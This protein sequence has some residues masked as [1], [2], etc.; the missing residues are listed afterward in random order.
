MKILDNYKGIALLSD[1]SESDLEYA[2]ELIRQG[3][4]VG[5]PTETVYGLGADALNEEAVKK[6]F[7]AKGRP[8]DNPLIVHI[9]DTEQMELYAHDILPAAY[10]LAHDFWPGPLT[11]ILPK[12]D[13]IPFAAS[14]GLDTVGIRMPQSEF[15]RKLIRKSGRP[16]AAPSANISGYPS[17]TTAMHVCH[18]M[19]GKIKAVVDGGECRVGLESTV[20]AFEKNNTIRILRPGFITPNDL[21]PYA[22]KIITDKAIL[23]GLS[24]DEKASSP[25]MKYKHYSPAANIIL[26]EAA[27]ADF[28]KYVYDLIPDKGTY[29]AA[30]GGEAK[31][32]PCSVIHY[33]N[34]PQE[35]AKNLFAV[36]RKLD[37]LDAKQ[38]YVHSPGKEGIGLAVYNRLIRAAG[39]EVI[40]L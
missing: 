5:I 1:N 15:T 32:C 19:Q 40:C 21:S 4:L 17:P 27:K 6:I 7:A 3:E 8:A 20:I 12:R 30:L 25:G 13:I 35:C 26:I 31:N 28:E 36:L 23:N 22:E 24:K 33:G 38:V 16:V 9:A 37:E 11:M 39:F 2:A 34:T 14:G 10:R 29:V 18:D